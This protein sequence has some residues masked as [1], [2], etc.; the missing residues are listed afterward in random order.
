MV[1]VSYQKIVF[2]QLKYIIDKKMH[3]KI[4]ILD[5]IIENMKR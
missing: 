5:D 4:N 3:K 1:K 2:I